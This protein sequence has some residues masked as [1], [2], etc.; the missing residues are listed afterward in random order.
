LSYVS[1]I[2]RADNPFTIGLDRLVDLEQ[3]ADFIGKAALKRIQKEGVK[4]RLVGV[5]IGGDPLEGG[6]QHF[7]SVYAGD[8]AVGHATRCVYSPQLEKNIGFV[9]VKVEFAEIG[10]ELSLDAPG[11][12]R[13]AKVV[14]T[15]FVESKKKI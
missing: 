5:E 8:D 7:W 2:T 12:R 4:R 3:D 9:N 1:D 11:G 14:P 10:N 6:N 13:V 15:P